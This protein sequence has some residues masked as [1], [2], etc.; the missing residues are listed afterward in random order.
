MGNNKEMDV[1]NRVYATKKASP[2][3]EAAITKMASSMGLDMQKLPTTLLNPTFF[4]GTPS[5]VDIAEYI[6]KKRKGAVK[7]SVTKSENAA[8]EPIQWNDD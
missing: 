4:G 3:D 2:S 8:G 7:K 5:F 6:L 1:L